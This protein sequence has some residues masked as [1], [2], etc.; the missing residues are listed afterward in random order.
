MG[1]VRTTGANMWPGRISGP[2]LAQLDRAS[3]FEPEGWGFEP[4]ERANLVSAM[5]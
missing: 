3:G 5:S 4:S 1:K 2:P